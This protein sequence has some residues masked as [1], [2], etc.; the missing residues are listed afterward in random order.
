[1]TTTHPPRRLGPL[2]AGV[3]SAGA[4]AILMTAGLVTGWHLA[5]GAVVALPVLLDRRPPEWQA[6]GVASGLLAVCT[7]V[8]QAQGETSIS[9]AYLTGCALC[10]FAATMFAVYGPADDHHGVTPDS[11]PA[12]VPADVPPGS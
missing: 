2:P 4:A 10:G 6:F 3:F 1:M 7:A 11:V 9:L 12:D 5:A 8:T